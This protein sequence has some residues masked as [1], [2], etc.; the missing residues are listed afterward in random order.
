MLAGSRVFKDDD[1]QARALELMPKV[2]KKD[3]TDE[4]EGKEKED[5]EENGQ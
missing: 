4:K 2:A 1:L 3:N 5:D